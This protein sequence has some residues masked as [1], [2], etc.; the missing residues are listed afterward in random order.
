[1]TTAR[2]AMRRCASSEYLPPDQAAGLGRVELGHKRRSFEE[3]GPLAKRGVI[4]QEV[5]GLMWHRRSSP[6]APASSIWADTTDVASSGESPYFEGRILGHLISK[7]N[8]S[9]TPEVPDVPDEMGAQPSVLCEDQTRPGSLEG[10]GEDRPKPSTPDYPE[11]MAG[12]DQ[13]QTLQPVPCNRRRHFRSAV[14]GNVLP[15]DSWHDL[16]NLRDWVDWEP[17]EEALSPPGLMQARE[18]MM[19][20]R[21][22]RIPLVNVNGGGIVSLNTA[23]ALVNVL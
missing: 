10:Q 20:S 4:E 18:A 6:F 16:K 9:V 12:A 7:C 22:P 8:A 1:M 17:F 19:S 15:A 21:T 11:G 2:L 13:E 23:A 14:K 5:V 3:V